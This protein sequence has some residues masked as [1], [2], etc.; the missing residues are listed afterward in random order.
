MCRLFKWLA[1]KQ[2]GTL[3]ELAHAEFASHKMHLVPQMYV[4]VSL[5]ECC[6]VAYKVLS[7]LSFDVSVVF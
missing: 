3:F 6:F 2:N 7:S 5:F 1:Q 4:F